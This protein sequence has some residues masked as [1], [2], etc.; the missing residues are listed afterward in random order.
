M[1]VGANIVIRVQPRTFKGITAVSQQ[2]HEGFCP[3]KLSRPELPSPSSYGHTF[4][5]GPDYILSYRAQNTP[6]THYH[7]VC[8]L[9]P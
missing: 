1:L 7:L 6:I 2:N 9:H 8:E 4:Q 5:C 3:H